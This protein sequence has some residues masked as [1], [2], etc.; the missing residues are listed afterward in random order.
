MR[1]MLRFLCVVVMLQVSTPLVHGM[2]VQQEGATTAATSLLGN[3]SKRLFFKRIVAGLCAASL[4]FTGIIWGG[5]EI[6]KAFPSS[7]SYR[8]YVLPP[9]PEV[10]WDKIE[11]GCL[12]GYNTDP[13]SWAIIE[14]QANLMGNDSGTPACKGGRDAEYIPVG[15]GRKMHLRDDLNCTKDL[16]HVFR[17]AV[18]SPEKAAEVEKIC[19]ER[20]IPYCAFETEN[21]T[22]L[23]FPD[24]DFDVAIDAERYLTTVATFPQYMEEKCKPL[25]DKARRLGECRGSFASN[26]NIPQQK[27]KNLPKHKT[28]KRH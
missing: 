2:D 26:Q 18:C 15:W 16:E 14:C 11:L 5:I 23:V 27:K 6:N 22:G 13:F 9:C 17:Y 24:K 1:L 19:D 3:S 21:G 20:G 4:F 10:P 25:A 8:P 7:H 12:E 28:R